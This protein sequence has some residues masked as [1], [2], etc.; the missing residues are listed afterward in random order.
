MFDG[1]PVQILAT[2]SPWFVTVTIVLAVT[3][4]IYTGAL[5]PR[6]TYLDRRAEQEKFVASLR[7]ALEE[8]RETNRELMALVRDLQAPSAKA[9][10]ILETVQEVNKSGPGSG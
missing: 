8:E 3:R 4:L 5:I 10:D 9:V 2:V 6:S 1:V 7:E